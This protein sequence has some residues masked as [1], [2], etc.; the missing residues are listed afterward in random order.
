MGE[1]LIKDDQDDLFPDFQNWFTERDTSGSI[2]GTYLDD[3]LLGTDDRDVLRGRRGD[4]TLNGGK[5]RDVLFGG[6]GSDLF[7]LSE[8]DATD[9]IRDFEL[10]TDKIELAIDDLGL[11]DVRLKTF[12]QK[13][14]LQIREDG[15]FKSIANLGRL[16]DAELSD[17]LLDSTILT[18]VTSLNTAAASSSLKVNSSIV[19]TGVTAFFPFIGGQRTDY[20]LLEAEVSDAFGRV[21][22][23]G[24]Q[25][26]F[27]PSTEI[28]SLGD[29]ETQTFELSFVYQSNGLPSQQQVVEV[30]ATGLPDG[31]IELTGGV[32]GP[33]GIERTDGSFRLDVLDTTDQ[34]QSPF[35][36]DGIA[37]PD[38]TLNRQQLV[39]IV[40]PL[41]K[42]ARTK[43]ARDFLERA[44]I[45]LANAKAVRDELR[46]DAGV[47]VIGAQAEVLARQA[48]LE[49]LEAL[50]P[51]AQ[52]TVDAAEALVA[53]LEDELA[54]AQQGVDAAQDLVEDLARSLDPLVDGSLAFVLDA[55][56]DVKDLAQDAVDAAQQ[57]L[58]DLVDAAGPLADALNAGI[59]GSAAFLLQ[60]KKNAL[61]LAQGAVDA[62]QV[63]F[64][65]ATQ[66]AE[67]LANELN[68]AIVGS[69]RWALDQAQSA[70]TIASN[71]LDTAQSLFNSAAAAADS[72]LSSVIGFFGSV[73]A[74]G[75]GAL[76]VTAQ[77]ALDAAQ[78]ALNNAGP[79]TVFGLPNPVYVAALAARNAARDARDAVDD[80]IDAVNLE[81]ARLSN[82][83]LAQNAA[84]AA[85][86]LLDDA[87]DVFDA[88]VIAANQA[89]QD[90]LN[91]QSELIS[92]QGIRDAA[93]EAVDDAQDD[94]DDAQDAFDANLTARIN[95]INLRNSLQNALTAAQQEVDAAQAAV[96]AANDALDDAVENR[97]SLEDI[98]SSINIDLLAAQDAVLGAVADLKDLLDNQIPAAQQALAD[99]EAALAAAIAA[100][101]FD[102]DIAALLA[103]L[104]LAEGEVLLREGEVLAAEA[105]LFAVQELAEIEAALLLET[106]GAFDAELGLEIQPLVSL[107]IEFGGSVNNGTDAVDVAS[108]STYDETT[109][110]LEVMPHLVSTE[111]GETVDLSS[112]ENGLELYLGILAEIGLRIEVTADLVAEFGDD[113]IDISP[114][115]D[116]LVTEIDLGV[117]FSIPFLNIAPGD[118]PLLPQT[119]D[120]LL[121]MTLEDGRQMTRPFGDFSAWA[122]PHASAYDAN[123]DGAIDV[124]LEVLPA[125][126]VDDFLVA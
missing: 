87:Q 22:I 110:I 78:F 91:K 41:L 125:E 60:Q 106:L 68:G 81:T 40:L 105:N 19:P 29:G 112:N 25:V 10:G 11:H 86:N 62:A 103:D 52:F 64:N 34:L 118:V 69:A 35:A 93:N 77:A 24:N 123:G 55:K 4:D 54:F 56:N 101:D 53:S 3:S 47:D 71:A 31:G 119:P 48:A 21:F 84:N 90:A 73:T 17:V 57:V 100:A 1:T 43:D 66:L 20:S 50:V 76:R 39:D 6:K 2:N 9:V 94:V 65:A 80:A 36:L 126:P 114:D 109:D 120:L 44:Q 38:F 33:R 45:D 88:A 28:D 83:T 102:G 96:D 67:D 85:N 18:P 116:G 111:S 95:Q 30:T 37:F 115:S 89:A 32:F 8:T 46:E 72:A 13:T 104:A 5:G 117:E 124:T 97:A 70:A 26:V 49:A 58:N 23:A 63:A 16:G 92:L 108:S 99:A 7:V 14:M 121:A 122:V 107:G 12:G 42:D 61:N 74:A 51:A 79:P 113:V 82:L 59:Q 75:L 98:V 15:R 27:T